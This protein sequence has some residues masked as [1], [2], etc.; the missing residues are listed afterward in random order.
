LNERE[1]KIEA[2]NVSAELAV[3]VGQQRE[4]IQTLEVEMVQQCEGRTN[5]RSK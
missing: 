1:S 2:E 4:R 5:S 3:Q